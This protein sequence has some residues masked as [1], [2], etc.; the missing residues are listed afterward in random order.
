MQIDFMITCVVASHIILL[1]LKCSVFGLQFDFLP[2]D[3]EDVVDNYVVNPVR[4]SLLNVIAHKIG[5]FDFFANL[6]RGT[7]HTFFRSYKKEPRR[8]RNGFPK[9]PKVRHE[10]KLHQEFSAIEQPFRQSSSNS[11][12]GIY[13][14]TPPNLA[15]ST[16]NPESVQMKLKSIKSRKEAIPSLQSMHHVPSFSDTFQD[17]A[18]LQ[19]LVSNPNTNNPNFRSIT[20]KNNQKNKNAANTN[21]GFESGIFPSSTI[22]R[23]PVMFENIDRLKS[24]F[25][26]YRIANYTILS[27]NQHLKILHEGDN[28]PPIFPFKGVSLSSSKQILSVPNLLHASM[29]KQVDYHGFDNN[30]VLEQSKNVNL[31]GTRTNG[32]EVDDS[33][34]RV[35][36]VLTRTEPDISNKN[37]NASQIRQKQLA[38]ISHN[39]LVE[40]DFF[41]GNASAH[42]EPITKTSLPKLKNVESGSSRGIRTAEI[43]NNPPS[44]TI[45]HQN[46]VKANSSGK[47]TKKNITLMQSQTQKTPNN[48]SETTIIE[49]TP[50]NILNN[51]NGMI[52]RF[53][54]FY[55]PKKKVFGFSSTNVHE[56]KRKSNKFRS[57]KRNIRKKRRNN[58]KSKTNRDFAAGSKRTSP[59]NDTHYDKYMTDLIHEVNVFS[60][61]VPVPSIRVKYKFYDLLPQM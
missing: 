51:T 26:M 41:K 55:S 47:E 43:L 6:I 34:R 7:K 20:P 40:C 57:E 50:R 5:F 49:T 48:I 19:K 10:P 46:L 14:M 17:V 59:Q 31:E 29:S 18:V 33:E 1:S 3:V 37:T 58:K 27:P 11:V 21:L 54:F 12:N 25:R 44:G 22:N 4:K 39:P 30:P 15:T 45:L 61:E 52:H 16:N 13:T 53:Q 24:P 36:Q 28:R 9:P 8:P 38:C 56:K 35:L 42:T 23:L 60:T 2:D 32:K